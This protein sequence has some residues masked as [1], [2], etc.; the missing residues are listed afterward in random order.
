M[1]VFRPENHSQL[2]PENQLIE[3]AKSGQFY[4]IVVDGPRLP[5]P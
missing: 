5:F 1:A 3:K 4:R 2:L